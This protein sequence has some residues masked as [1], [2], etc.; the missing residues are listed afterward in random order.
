LVLMQ[1]LV[2]PS[3]LDLSSTDVTTTS[4]PQTRLSGSGAVHKPL[5]R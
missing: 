1:V 5:S 3:I 2:A 4:V